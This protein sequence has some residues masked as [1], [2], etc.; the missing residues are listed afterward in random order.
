[1][2]QAF[3]ESTKTVKYFGAID[4][5]TDN[6]TGYIALVEAFVVE[7]GALSGWGV[8]LGG[9]IQVPDGLAF[10]KKH[11][12]VKLA[13]FDTSDAVYAALDAGQILFGVD[14]N[15]YLQGYFAVP[16]LAWKSYANQSLSAPYV[17]TGP[18]LVTASPLKVEVQCQTNMYKTCAPQQYNNNDDATSTANSA[19]GTTTSA[20]SS[21][22]IGSGT[23]MMA[24]L[25]VSLLF[26]ALW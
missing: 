23:I 19:G 2:A 3:S 14:Q 10:Q 13:T 9:A 24:I 21:Q 1:M 8:L 26:T 12:N 18:R 15:A 4:V 22:L 5:P 11:A 25:G 6:T 20:A 16:L 17:E 7:T